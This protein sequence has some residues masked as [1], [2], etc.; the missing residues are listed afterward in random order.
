MNK[1]K[2]IFYDKSDILVAILIF[3]VA[4]GIIFWRLGAIMDYPKQLASG[5][6]HIVTDVDI[7]NQQQQAE[8]EAQQNAEA[9]AQSQ[10]NTNEDDPFAQAVTEGDD[11]GKDKDKT[12]ES[13]S[14]WQD[15]KLTKTV[16]VEVSGNTALSAIN[17][18]VDAGLFKSYSEYESICKDLGY[19]PEQVYAGSF[20]FQEGSTKEIIVNKVNLGN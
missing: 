17:C 11:K 13:T 1:L 5:G 18:L 8:L 14:L 9:Q 4:F 6:S 12:Q 16:N 19:N 15:G 2:D 20:V 7:A 3:A 10:E